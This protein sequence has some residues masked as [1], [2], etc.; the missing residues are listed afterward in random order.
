M[1][2]NRQGSRNKY[3]NLCPAQKMKESE[4]N[5]FIPL[6][7]LNDKLRKQLNSGTDDPDMLVKNS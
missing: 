7:Y 1:S 3:E 5:M 6:M 4:N 2:E